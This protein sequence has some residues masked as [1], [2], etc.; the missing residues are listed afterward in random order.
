MNQAVIME[1]VDDHTA[2]ALTSDMVFVRIAREPGMMIGAQVEIPFGQAVGGGSTDARQVSK[3]HVTRTP[4]AS[5]VV[6]GGSDRF[7]RRKLAKR[8]RTVAIGS[9]AAVMVLAIVAFGSVQNAWAA[10]V[11][12]VSVDVNPSIEL[13]VNDQERV[14]AVDAMDAAGARMLALVHLT[15]LPI[16]QAIDKYLQIVVRA[17][18]VKNGASVIVT[19]SAAHSGDREQAQVSVF[20]RIQ[21]VAS[22]SP[23]Q[24][25]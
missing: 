9:A 17:G 21:R 15:D 24:S 6:I 14:V 11:A 19:T 1:F 22:G 7:A 2:I 16:R 5:G 18:Y 23:R 20:G 10:P 12:Y 4:V 3:G 13:A 25:Y 8:T